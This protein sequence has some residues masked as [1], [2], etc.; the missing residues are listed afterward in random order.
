MSFASNTN[1]PAETLF[2]ATDNLNNQSGAARLGTIDV[3]GTFTLGFVGDF[4]PPIQNAELTG[5]GDGRLFAF[6][7]VGGTPNQP[8]PDSAI[9]EIDKTTA[10]V[11]AETPLP[12]I[13][14]GS[15]WAFGFWGGDFYTF[16]SPNSNGSIVTRVRPSDGSVTTVGNLGSN[17]VGAGVS[18]CAPEQ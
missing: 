6:Y 13:T 7:S 8:G 14:Q 1:G 4:N 15:A 9:G 5:T 11:I 10:R 12:G 3:A 16:T 18:T 17:I 2:I